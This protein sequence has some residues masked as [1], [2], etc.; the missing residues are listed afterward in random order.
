MSD[1]NQPYSKTGKFVENLKTTQNS[2]DEDKELYSKYVP[3]YIQKNWKSIFSKQLYG[4]GKDILHTNNLLIQYGFTKQRPPVPEQGSSQ[5]SFTDKNDQIHL[6]GFG[7]VFASGNHGLYLWRHEFVP[8][9]LDINSLPSNVWS[10]EQLP[11]CTIP[12]T[13]DE[14][15]L[16]LQLLVK[17]IKWLERYENWVVATCG[18]SYRDKSLRSPN[19]SSTSSLYLDQK[20]SELNEKFEKILKNSEPEPVEDVI[21]T[22]PVQPNFEQPS[23]VPKNTCGACGENYPEDMKFCPS[24][25]WEELPC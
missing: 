20:W 8:K 16:M 18:Q 17:S 6:W 15:S 9:L 14:T 7:M 13:P 11:E 3:K 23:V 5:Y 12:K 4:I 1:E 2:T 19:S 22:E 24:C 25:S 21:E 10:P